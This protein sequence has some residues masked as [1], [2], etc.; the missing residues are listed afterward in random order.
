[1][2]ISGYQYHAAEAVMSI[3]FDCN[4]KS[5]V[6]F[7]QFLAIAHC[8]R[9]YFVQEKRSKCDVGYTCNPS[10]RKIKRAGSAP[11]TSLASSLSMDAVKFS[12]LIFNREAHNRRLK[13]EL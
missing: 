1:M 4:I 8:S 2:M 13:N 12:S 7:N 3:N 5:G 11:V 10:G 9:F 6:T